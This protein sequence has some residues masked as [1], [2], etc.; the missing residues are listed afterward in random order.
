MLCV[1]LRGVGI[2]G[3]TPTQ[4]VKVDFQDHDSSYE[5][6]RD[7]GVQVAESK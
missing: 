2:V 1:F 5:K 7:L 3:A 4:D 6:E